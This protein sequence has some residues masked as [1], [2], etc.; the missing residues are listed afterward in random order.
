MEEP[1]LND[2]LERE[3]QLLDQALEQ[4]RHT[5]SANGRA[6]SLIGGAAA[7]LALPHPAA[8]ARRAA[9]DPGGETRTATSTVDSARVDRGPAAGAQIWQRTTGATGER[10]AAA[11]KSN[12]PVLAQDGPAFEPVLRS[13]ERQQETF[14]RHLAKRDEMLWTLIDR[15]IGGR[16]NSQGVSDEPRSSEPSVAERLAVLERQL[17][18]LTSAFEVAARQDGDKPV[19]Q[20]GSTEGPA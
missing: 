10:E 16:T 3:Q 15:V 5:R 13:L 2:R 18:R 17:A 20:A 7:R 11:A 19:A 8:T 4:A 12:L 14:L 1:T 6:P 9:P